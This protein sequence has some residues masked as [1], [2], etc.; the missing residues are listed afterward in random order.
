MPRLLALLSVIIIWCSACGEPRPAGPSTTLADQPHALDHYSTLLQ[1]ELTDPDPVAVH[2]EISCEVGR[3]GCAFGT[4]EGRRRL[5]G[6]EDSVF[7]SA[8]ARAK[9]ARVE[10]VL[11]GHDFGVDGAICDSVNAIWNKQLPLTPTADG[12]PPRVSRTP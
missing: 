9:F 7:R 4:D 8:D 12:L 6:V 1:R 11:V 2:Q 3:I 5:G 10:D